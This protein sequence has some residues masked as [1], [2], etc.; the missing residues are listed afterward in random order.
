[1]ILSVE[2]F[3]SLTAASVSRVPAYVPGKSTAETVAA[4]HL[5]PAGVIKLSS[6]ENPLGPSPKAVAA[7]AQAVS[8]ISV[9]PAADARD[10]RAAIADRCGLSAD[11]VVVSGPGMDGLIDA[12][13]KLFLNPG[14]EVIVLTPTFSFYEIAAAARGALP[15]SVERNAQFDA[16]ADAVLNAVTERTKIIFICSP[17]NPTGNLMSEKDVRKI[18][19]NSGCIVFLDEAYIE[20]AD[21]PSLAP[22]V[23][24]YDNLIVGRTFSKIF[25]L[26]GLRVGY[27]LTPAWMT[28]E[29]LRMSLP[30]SVTTV[31]EAAAIAALSDDDHIDK[32]RRSV[33]DGRRF[34]LEQI[35]EKTPFSVY[36]SSGN[37]VMIDV[38]PHTSKDICESLLKDGVIVRGCDSFRGAGKTLVR[39][40]VGTS[41]MN[42]RVLESL[43][44]AAEKDGL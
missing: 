42:A 31:T 35:P 37:F 12:V 24:E 16:D 33:A 10:L 5:D 21:A 3:R 11:R 23:C 26:A 36:P 15:V 34:F 39:I 29:I 13:C 22:L 27:G 32:S 1:M 43:V 17:N 25:G 9:Y 2:Q 6:N 38:A 40:T 30:F 41:E 14:D 20:F 4:Y 18:A 28:P 7:A 44:K 8:D 19:E